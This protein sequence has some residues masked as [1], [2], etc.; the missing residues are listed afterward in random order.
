MRERGLTYDKALAEVLSENKSPFFG[1]A[2]DGQTVAINRIYEQL[3]KLS[4]ERTALMQEILIGNNQPSVVSAPT[5]NISNVNQG[6]TLP[7][8]AMHDEAKVPGFR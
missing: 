3:E 7:F 8:Q 1:S 6:F 5:N 2:V 4:Q